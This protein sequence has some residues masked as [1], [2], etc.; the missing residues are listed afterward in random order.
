MTNSQWKRPNRPPHKQMLNL[1]WK[2]QFIC[3][4]L[5]NKCNPWEME[6][7]NPQGETDKEIILRWDELLF[8]SFKHCVYKV[9]L[10]FGS[11][12]DQ[13]NS[14][15]GCTFENT[16]KPSAHERAQR[17]E[18][19]STHCSGGLQ[20]GESTNPKPPG[21]H[22]P[23]AWCLKCIRSYFRFYISLGRMAYL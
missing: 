5:N 2:A 12:H 18:G 22:L 14:A 10:P 15:S 17:A 6:K 9:V 7:A 13:N 8:L 23:S 16:E 4:K 20:A 21:A 11:N 1:C 19:R 3:I